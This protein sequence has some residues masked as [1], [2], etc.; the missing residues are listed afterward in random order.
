MS[1]TDYIHSHNFLGAGHDDNAK[2]T[3]WVV[4]L[5][6]VMMVGEIAAG[7]ITGSMAL[8]ADGFHMATHAGALGIAAAAYAFA[9][10]HSENSAYSFGTGKVGDLGGFASALILGLISLGIGVE[11]V[12][13]LLEPTQVQFGMATLIAVIGLIVNIVSALL[14]AGGGHDHAHGHTHSHDHHGQ[15]HGED[16]NLRSAYVHVLAD[17]VTSVLAIVALLA[18]KYLGWVWLDPVMGI[19]GAVVIARWAWSL[20]RDTASVLLDKTDDHVAEEIRE[21][22]NQ[23]GTLQITDLHVWRVGPQARAAIVSVHGSSELSADDVR[24]ALK[25]VHEVTHLTVEYRAA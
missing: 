18:G 1:T 17:A 24:A 6:V 20:M 3:L 10:K 4:G 15:S 21:L 25:P 7:Y 2:R 11:S 5:T 8:L 19:V 14:L 9:R 22:L 16:N 12:M 23:S 13:R